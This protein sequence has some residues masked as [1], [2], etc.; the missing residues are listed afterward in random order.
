MT[1][2][3]AGALVPRVVPV[4]DSAVL[5][6]LGETIDPA[7]NDRVHE[8]AEAVRALRERDPRFGAPTPA[9]A[10]MLVPFDPLSIDPGEAVAAMAALALADARPIGPRPGTTPAGQ[11]HG[12][13]VEIPV[14]YGGRDG[15]DLEAVADLARLSPSEV[16]AIHA[17]TAYRCY[18][19]G[20]R[21]GFG[22]LGPLDP[23]IETPRLAT[24]RTVVPAGSV[25][26][27]GR[28]TGVYPM[29]SP[30]GW[31]IIGRTE[32]RTWDPQRN[33]PALLRP[34][35]TVRFVAVE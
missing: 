24:P 25:G 28:Q 33:P 23:R 21:P 3:A 32:V 30:G 19:L 7:L 11:P 13:V 2:T 27:A 29:D 14:R 18:M 12:E 4:G 34:G 10:S 35:V 31:Q 9:Y 8:L 15:P 17:G 20:F 1:A 22:Y 6:V 26:V 5:V 16:V